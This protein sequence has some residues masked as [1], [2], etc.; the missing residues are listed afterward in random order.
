[1]FRGPAGISAMMKEGAA[2]Y[3]GTEEAVL[4]NVDAARKLYETVKSSYG[5]TGMCKLVNNYIEKRFLT[6]DA[7]TIL[8]ELEVQHPAA[9]VLVMASQMQN[10]EFGDHTNFVVILAAEL[11]VQAG[12]LISAGVHQSF[13]IKGYELALAR[14]LEVLKTRV[15]KTMHGCDDL[16]VRPLVASKVFG[17]ANVEVVT[18]LVKDACNTVLLSEDGKMNTDNIRV[19][20]IVGGTLT[21]SC[22]V[23]GMVFLREPRTEAKEKRNCKI[24]LLGTALEGVQTEGTSTVLIEKAEHM[25]NFTQGEEEEMENL[26]KGY[27]DAGV[28]AVIC[29]GA[30]SSLALHFLNKYDMWALPV[31]SRFDIKRLSRTLRI[32]ALQRRSA[33]MAE[34]IGL[35]EFVGLKE[36]GS[37]L[38][39]VVQGKDTK[40]STILLRG[41][42]M[43]MLDEVARAVDDCV[44]LVSAVCRDDRFVAGAGNAELA[45]SDDL[46]QYATTLAGL[47]QYSVERFGV[48]LA[49]FPKLLAENAGHNALETMSRLI[50]RFKQTEQAGSKTEIVGVDVTSSN[51][52]VRDISEP[53]ERDEFAAFNELGYPVYD[54]YLTKQWAIRLAADAALTL[55]RVDQI[56]MSKPA[57]GP[58]MPSQGHWDAAD[59]REPAF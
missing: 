32:P 1:M 38:V 24:I 37:Q 20:K 19:S 52:S 44:S 26:I 12:E 31:P 56:I 48:A 21:Q 28:E 30:I 17:R 57:G 4:R 27:H 36:I 18:R 29:G 45:L 11:L 47:E 35:A 42:A 49:A 10:S 51:N 16:M 14:S 41:G 9:R 46:E 50:A 22:V 43:T 40:V 59:D 25:K 58:K 2:H 7:S 34:E 6:A 5:P 39:T 53:C 3:K 15:C 23:N 55:L 33:P 13:I 8:S 54:H